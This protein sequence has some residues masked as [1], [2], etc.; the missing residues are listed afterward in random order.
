MLTSRCLRRLVGVCVQKQRRAG[1]EGKRHEW[2]NAE[3]APGQD[4]GGKAHGQKQNHQGRGA[5][6]GGAGGKGGYKGAK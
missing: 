4:K 6:G 5:Q 1:F 2:L 3:G